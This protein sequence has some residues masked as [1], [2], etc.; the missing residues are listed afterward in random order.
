MSQDL[1][2]ER[3]IQEFVPG[4]QVTLAHLIANPNQ[5]V[6]TNLGLPQEHNAIGIMTITPSEGAIIAA[7][8]ARKS[9]AI[10]LGFVDRFSGSLVFTGEVSSVEYALSQVCMKLKDILGF[11]VTEITKT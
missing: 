6:F 8:I 1:V 5:S 9:G 2:K 7:D 4:K 11:D 3:I 10:E